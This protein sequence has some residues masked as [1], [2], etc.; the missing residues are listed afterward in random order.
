MNR[1]R[2]V[3][4]LRITWTG[5]WGLA[6]ILLVAL[7]VR[8]YCFA[9]GI[10]VPL[11]RSHDLHCGY[12]SGA[13]DFTLLNDGSG[14]WVVHSDSL[15]LLGNI[16]SR[17]GLWWTLGFSFDKQPYGSL[18]MLPFW[19]L[20]VLSLSFAMGPWVSR[21]KRF[22]LRTLLIATTLVGVGLGTVAWLSG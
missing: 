1:P 10:L 2:L 13:I 7:W 19:L 17:Q 6:A 16:P 20:V 22:S 14:Q 18:V 8:S 3:R 11:T 12:G 4:A 5:F 21:F 9:E 15:E